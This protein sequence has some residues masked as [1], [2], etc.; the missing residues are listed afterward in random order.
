MKPATWFRRL[1]W[2]IVVCT[3]LLIGL[4]W[5]GIARFEELT[6]GGGRLL[7]RQMAYSVLALLAMLGASL[8]NYRILCRFSYALFLIALA[9]LVAVYF[10]PPINKAHRWIRL[11]PIGLQPS[12]LAKVAFVLAL[13]QYLMYRENYRRLRGLAAPLALTLVPVL[14]I[15][16]E[17]DLGTA[18][19]FLPVLFAMLFAAGARRRDLAWM[20]VAGLLTLP[21]LWTQMSPDQ[22]SRVTAL[23]D[24]PPPGQ[25]P[26]DAAYQ[27]YQAKQ[28]RA[29]GGTWGSLVA[30]QLSED[31]AAYR[32]PEA[33]SDFILCVLGE[34]LGLPGL[35]LVLGLYVAL[36]WRGLVIAMETREPYGRLLAVGIA[37]LFAVEV[38]IHGGVSVGLLPIT[39]LSLPLV[40]YGGSGLLA[41][42]LAIGLLLNVGLRPGYEVTNEPFR[43]VVERD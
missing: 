23:F 22:Q 28:M 18:M 9:M 3:T 21:L 36:V 12:E 8:P 40:S 32:L 15:L 1:P 11:G 17:P 16:K 43:Y 25:R 37:T 20:V 34:R 24:Q 14:L 30:G 7:H 42:A 35:A 31:P 27:L 33:Q 39:G 5:L 41:H 4:G 29:M 26:S 13:A 19:V 6:D 38:L 2:S 10:F